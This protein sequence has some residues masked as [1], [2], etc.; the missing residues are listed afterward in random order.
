MKLVLSIVAVLATAG[1]VSPEYKAFQ[2]NYA[3]AGTDRK[4]ATRFNG[5]VYTIGPNC[6]IPTPTV[7]PNSCYMYPVPVDQYSTGRPTRFNG[8]VYT[9]SSNCPIPTPDP[10]PNFCY[11][12]PVPVG[13]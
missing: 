9:V 10:I 4:P 6:P 2:E 11:K 8:G 7:I 1:C 5:G 13:Q 3:K 12:Y